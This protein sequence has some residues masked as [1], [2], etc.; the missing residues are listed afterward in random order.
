MG[1]IVNNSSPSKET[2]YQYR[3][4]ESVSDQCAPPPA[5]SRCQGSVDIIYSNA[6]QGQRLIQI[7]VAGTQTRSNSSP[8]DGDLSKYKS[9]G[10]RLIQI[11]VTLKKLS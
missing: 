11:S 10:R 7:S 4:D 6:S 8:R 9:K 1:Y 3:V 2:K 5:L